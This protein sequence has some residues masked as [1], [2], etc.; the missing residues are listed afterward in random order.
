MNAARRLVELGIN[1]AAKDAV[2]IYKLATLC[3]PLPLGAFVGNNYCCRHLADDLSLLC[4]LIQPDNQLVR[5][6][7]LAAWSDP[8]TQPG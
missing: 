6:T 5:R 3:L 8:L 2:N 7:Q 1:K 4:P